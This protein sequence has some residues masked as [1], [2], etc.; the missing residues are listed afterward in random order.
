[1]ETQEKYKSF[2]SNKSFNELL[3]NMEAEALRLNDLKFELQFYTTLLYKPIFKTRTANLFEILARYKY[4]IGILQEKRL[5]LLNRINDYILQI[6]N[7]IESRAT[8]F[9]G[10]FINN[11]DGLEMEIFNFHL[12]ISDFKFGYFE[13]IQSVSLN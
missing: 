12:Q 6:N 8:A 1:M 10:N 3:Y 4:D 13:Y 5:K 2:N 7:K 11:Y 9:N